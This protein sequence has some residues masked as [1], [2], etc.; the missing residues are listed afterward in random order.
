[1]N[2]SEITD[3]QLFEEVKEVVRLW[4]EGEIRTAREAQAH[5]A[6]HLG[7]DRRAID[8]IGAPVMEIDPYIFNVG[9]QIA[10]DADGTARPEV[11]HDKVWHRMMRDDCPGIFVDA[12]GTKDIHVGATQAVN[13]SSIE[14]TGPT[15]RNV[16]SSTSYG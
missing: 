6:K 9:A 5:V 4:N 1:M 14:F 7:T 13:S 2:D 3:E 16:R 10:A 15:G 11:W 12:G 8:G